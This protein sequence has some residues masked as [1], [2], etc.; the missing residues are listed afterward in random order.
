MKSIELKE[1]D[2]SEELDSSFLISL[3]IFLKDKGLQNVFSF[4]INRIKTSSYAGAIKFKGVQI[5][6]L[7]K[8][9]SEGE[10]GKKIVDNLIFMLSYTKKL[11]VKNPSSALISKSP[12]PFIEILISSYAESLLSALLTNIPHDYEIQNGNLRFIKGKIDFRN[13][14]KYN[15][16]NH[17]KLYCIFDEFKEDNLLNQIFKFVTQ[18]LSN[19]SQI[20]DTKNKL[21]KIQAIYDDVS[22]KRITPEISDNVELK[23]GQRVFEIP[24]KLAKLFIDNTSIHIKSN[25]FDSIALLFDMNKLF[26]EFIFTA[27]KSIYGANVKAQVRKGMLKNLYYGNDVIPFKKH[28]R[29]DIQIN[30]LTKQP[31]ILDTKYKIINSAKDISID[32]IYQ[33]IAYSKVYKTDNLIL[34]YPKSGP[35]LKHSV[36]FYEDIT[37]GRKLN[38]HIATLNLH[39]NLKNKHFMSDLKH[40]VEKSFL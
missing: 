20:T 13:D 38:I 5:N 18:A 7:P 21:K 29:S 6:V 19:V 32:D 35:A 31:I 4:D 2:L 37:I 36:G 28:T 11:K 14:I 15:S 10:D 9:I 16:S 34:L 3:K 17:A 30:G 26:E 25:N 12:N 24:F 23:R 39:S 8:I 1:Y 40:I 22:L 33:M 27:L